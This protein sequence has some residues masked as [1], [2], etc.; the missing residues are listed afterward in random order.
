LNID[1]HFSNTK[2]ADYN[3][4]DTNACSTCQVLFRLFNDNKIDITQKIATYLYTGLSTDTGHFMHNNVTADIF[5]MAAS[6]T[7]TGINIENIARNLYKQNS[8]E[9]LKLVSFCLNS[10]QYFCQD[11]IAIMVLT[12]QD[13]AKCGATIDDTEGLVSYCI[14]QKDVS[15]GAMMTQYGDNSFKI[16]MRSLP[17]I[18][19]S[20][21]ASVFGGGGHKQAAGCMIFGTKDTVL[22]KLIKALSDCI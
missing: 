1:H 9:R 14:N 2:F 12:K 7:K 11:K 21:A 22:E 19:V 15:I 16:S 6:L 17:E 20:R 8:K 13:L 18:D 5:L 4:V 3:L 10:L